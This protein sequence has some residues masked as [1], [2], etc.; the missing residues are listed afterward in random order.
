MDLKLELGDRA[1]R[2]DMLFENGGCPITRDFTDS[3]AQRV[4][5]MLRTFL[6][7]W[8][9]NVETGV[10]YTQRILGHRIDKSTVDR[11]LQERILAEP[12]VGGILEFRSTLNNKREYDVVLKIRDTSGG[13]LTVTN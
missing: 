7:E 11:I 5:M 2:G 4:F 6:G 1:G 8:Y 13:T 10:P 3:V 12:G 9:L